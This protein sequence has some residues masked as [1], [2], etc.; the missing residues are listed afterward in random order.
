MPDVINKV[1]DTIPTS[2]VVTH[3][4]SINHTPKSDCVWKTFLGTEGERGISR[5]YPTDNERIDILKNYGTDYVKYDIHG[6]PDFSPFVKT[7]V[8]I[9]NMSNRRL[10]TDGNFRSAAE[11]LVGSEWA[12]EKGLNSVSAIENYCKKYNLTWHEKRDG[13]TMQLI[14]REVHEKFPH[15]GGISIMSH[16]INE[17][18]VTVGEIIIKANQSIVEFQEIINNITDAA[19]NF[20]SDQTG[21]FMSEDFKQINAAGINEAVNSALFAAAFSTAINIHS[22]INNEKSTKEAVKEIIYD[23]ASAAVLGYATGAI[24]EN[25]NIERSDASLLVNAT[26]QISKKVLSYVNGEIDEKQLLNDVTE[27]IVC[28]AAAHIGKIIGDAIIP[29]IGGFVGQY[30]GEMITTAVCVEVM[31]TIK[32]SKE[33]DKQNSKI[34]SLYRSAEAEIRA[35]QERL[36]Y[37]IQRENIELLNTINRG[38]DEIALG[39]QNDSHDQIFRGLF[40]IGEKFRLTEDDFTNGFV[41]QDNLF[42]DQNIVVFN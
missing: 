2:G 16:V 39:I 14:P 15:L 33:F 34:I 5:C 19:K 41:T 23:T 21:R 37:I 22:V 40:I 38:F 26:V 28:S 32:F 42:D 3:K 25:L 1:L 8:K 13:V 6:E 4:E 30:I 20:I 29:G 18:G 27:T 7:E 9:S 35:S 17:D 24:M 10:G 12:K 11:K 31:S 36:K